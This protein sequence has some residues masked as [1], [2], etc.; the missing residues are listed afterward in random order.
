MQIAWPG[1]P[2]R[3]NCLSERI[4]LAMPSPRSPK[5]R[6]GAALQSALAGLLEEAGRALEQFDANPAVEAHFLRTRVKRLQSVSRLLPSAAVWRKEFLPPLR[7]LKDLFAGVRDATIVQAL[8]A[9]YAP[10]QSVR[11]GEPVRPD[12]ARA[13]VLLEQAARALAA[14]E[15]WAQVEW[16]QLAD[17]AV[18]TYRAARN[19][20]KV[21]ARR[22]APDA[23]FH[24]WRRREKRLFY[25]CQFLGR[26]ASL[27]RITKRADRLGEV[28]GEIQDVC[29]AADWLAEQ[30][31]AFVPPDLDRTKDKLKRQALCL[32]SAL[33]SPKPGDFRKLLGIEAAA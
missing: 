19:A 13:A 14:R 2:L 8:I 12:L 24:E 1:C 23:A 27:V 20:W 21:A 31:A 11:A 30:Q 33:F 18:G 16:R 10:G 32:G 15:G 29:M 7:E 3:R 26:G 22:N 5:L 17:R 28:L 6:A 4:R 25:Q 9:K